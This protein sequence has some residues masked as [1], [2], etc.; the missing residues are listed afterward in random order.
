MMHIMRRRA[1]YYII[2]LAIILPGLVSLAIPPHLKLAVD[3]TGGTLWEL[4]F[5]QAVQPAEV[6]GVMAEKGY[7]DA[8]V[9]TS[10]DRGVLIRSKEIPSEGNTKSDI[11]QALQAKFGPA[12]ELRFESVGPV[13]GQEVATRAIAAVFLA[14]IGILLYIAWAFRKV[15]HPVRYGLCAIIALL[16]DALVV[17]GIFSIL[18]HLFN[19]E[20][21]SLFVTAVLTVIGFSV[22]DTI[23]VF[24]RIREN[25][26][27]MHGVPFEDVVNHSLLQTLG[28]SLATSLTVLFTL[29]ALTLFGGVT[30]RLFALTLLIGIISGTYSSIFNASALL[31]SWEN[32]DLGRLFGRRRVATA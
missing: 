28:R 17:L 26:R 14:S 10:G 23:V 27:R 12:T 8:V 3:F 18:G 29:S 22:H 5:Q 13:I 24:D 32:G 2:S 7:P 15:D 6:K 31:V 1:L 16:H 20:V 30:I 9:Q 11:L 19:V 25:A 21:D 4:Q